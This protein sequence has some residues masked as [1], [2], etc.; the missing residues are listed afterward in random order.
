MTDLCSG[1]SSRSFSAIALP[2]SSNLVLWY[3]EARKTRYQSYLSRYRYHGPRIP[4]RRIGGDR[5]FWREKIPR[6]LST[7]SSLVTC[8]ARLGHLS[9]FTL[10]APGVQENARASIC[11]EADVTN[12]AALHPVSS[13]PNSYLRSR[14]TTQVY[15]NAITTSGPPGNPGEAR[16]TARLTAT[17]IRQARS[18]ESRLPRNSEQYPRALL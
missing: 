16:T 11:Y 8:V 1:R 4:L 10:R 7:R 18:L 9:L 5:I 3:L 6:Q 15:L 13:S 12:H 17:N 14:E 2:Y